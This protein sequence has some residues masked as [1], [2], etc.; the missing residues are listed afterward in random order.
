VLA[1]AWS[2]KQN[3]FA[4]SNS[5]SKANWA[6]SE[7]HWREKVTALV[8]CKLNRDAST[9]H[10]WSGAYSQV[11]LWDWTRIKKPSQQKHKSSLRFLLGAVYQWFPRKEKQADSSQHQVTAYSNMTCNINESVMETLPLEK[12]IARH[13]VLIC[14]KLT[15][16]LQQSRLLLLRRPKDACNHIQSFL[17]NMPNSNV[18]FCNNSS[19]WYL[20]KLFQL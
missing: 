10:G 6:T 14:R 17:F 3:S 11:V 8:K 9:V 18:F 13:S 19:F 5:F 20:R 4:W 1:A 7:T 16:H 12:F 2:K 15:L